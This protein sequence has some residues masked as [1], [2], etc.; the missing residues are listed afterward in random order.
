MS[1]DKHILALI[2]AAKT[3]YKASA[4][5]HLP[6]RKTHDPYR[7]L[8]SEV[9]LQQTQVD[10]VVPFYKSFLKKFPTA[11]ALAK[12]PLSKVLKA[13]QGL[14]YNRRGKYL[15]EAAKIISTKGWKG[16]LPGVGLY[17]A[18][19][20]QAFAHNKPAVFIETNIRTVFFYHLEDSNILKKV[21][22]TDVELL[23]LIEE[24]LKKSKMQPRDFYAALMDYGSHLK[25]Q[26][27]KLNQKS[28]H[29]AKQSK[30]EGSAR[31]K[32]ANKLR[33]LLAKGASERELEKT[34]DLR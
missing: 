8:V 27:I 17:T 5:T 21:R 11:K 2:K 28:K 19:A 34:L 4:R 23:P 15:W 1:K 7:I 20:V 9:M 12:A 29:Y 18:A 13:W 24:A 32:R 30:F 6:W 3:H 22:I 10:R 33:E 31:Q 14:G 25:K 16:K 26:G